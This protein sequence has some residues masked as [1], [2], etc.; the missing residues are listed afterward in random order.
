VD[1]EEDP[2]LVTVFGRDIRERI[3]VAAKGIMLQRVK[4]D[5]GQG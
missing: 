1:C 3:V 2:V 4:C 5:N